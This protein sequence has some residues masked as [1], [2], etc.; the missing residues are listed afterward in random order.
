MKRLLK[1]LLILFFIPFLSFTS[2]SLLFISEKS[3]TWLFE[4][5]SEQ[6]G[7]QSEILVS[8]LDWSLTKSRISLSELSI[9]EED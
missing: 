2:V 1:Y 4:S 7:Y 6:L 9:Q 8:D 3:I 5:V